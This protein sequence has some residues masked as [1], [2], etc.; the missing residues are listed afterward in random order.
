M[1]V[2]GGG[3]RRGV[4]RGRVPVA[5]GASQQTA[6]RVLHRR[7]DVRSP[8]AAAALATLVMVVMLMMVTVLLMLLLLLARR[9]VIHDL[10]HTHGSRG[11][12]LITVR[13][14]H[15]H[16]GAD[17]VHVRSNPAGFSARPLNEKS[18]RSLYRPR[19][20]SLALLT[21]PAKGSFSPRSIPRT[22]RQ[23]YNFSNQE[24]SPLVSPKRWKFLTIPRIIS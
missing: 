22:V 19:R 1:A 24:C 11:C 16:R 3:H 21:V 17:A 4:R 2:D 13:L 20:N 23:G 5:L 12:H 7:G 8:A 10:F 15:V 6:H 9:F 18:S 14:H